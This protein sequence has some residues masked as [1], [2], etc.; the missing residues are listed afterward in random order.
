MGS[1]QSSGFQHVSAKTPIP[2]FVGDNPSTLE[3]QLFV[4]MSIVFLKGVLRFLPSISLE[5]GDA[6]SRVEV[7]SN[8]DDRSGFNFP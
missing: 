6:W 1:W 7:R 4:W 5:M 2:S 3:V 8:I